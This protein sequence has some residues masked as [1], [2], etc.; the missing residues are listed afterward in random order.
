MCVSIDFILLLCLKVLLE[1]GRFIVLVAGV[2][3]SDSVIHIHIFILFQIF[4][5]IGYYRLLIEFPVLYSRSLL[6]I[7]VT[8]IIVQPLWGYLSPTN[9]HNIFFSWAETCR[10]WKNFKFGFVML[11]LVILG[12]YLNSLKLRFLISNVRLA[13]PWPR[14]TWSRDSWIQ[15]LCDQKRITGFL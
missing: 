1:Y 6:V 10:S 8:H 13:P 2:Q 3:Q 9:R 11:W 4:S 14:V 5:H 15:A 12:K 7:H